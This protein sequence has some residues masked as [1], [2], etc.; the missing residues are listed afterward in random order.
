MSNCVEQQRPGEAPSHLQASPS[1]R[2]LEHGAN[3]HRHRCHD[4]N[5]ADGDVALPSSPPPRPADANYDGLDPADVSV[6]NTGETTSPAS[7]S[8]RPA[9]WSPQSMVDR[10]AAPTQFSVVV[11][12]SRPPRTGR[13]AGATATPPS[14]VSPASLT[15]TPTELRYRPT[16]GRALAW[17]TAVDGDVSYNTTPPGD[18]RKPGLRWSRPADVSNRP[19]GTTTLAG[20]TVTRPPVWSPP[21]PVAA[22][23][24]TV[25]LANQPD[26]DNPAS[27]CPAAIP[28]A[29]CHRP[30]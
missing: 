3:R 11:L 13:P 1:R 8:P 10:R 2:Q 28:P 7:P 25:V 6:T 19:T 16:R 21:R 27:L 26:S 18:Q 4:D 17:T 30:A 23:T 20:I 22:T 9:V 5:M 24:N 14:T 12:N 29:R 15:F